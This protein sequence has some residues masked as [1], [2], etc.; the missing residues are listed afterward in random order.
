MAV[1][2]N[3]KIGDKEF[4]R[5]YG[6][7]TT[8]SYGCPS[9]E[10]DIYVYRMTMTNEDGDVVEYPWDLVKL[11]CEQM[12]AK[13]VPEFERFEFT[14]DV[15]LMARV[16]A[17]VGGSDPIGLKHVREGVVVR[18]ENKEHFSAYKHKN[19]EFKVLEG[20]IKET[21]VEPDM[22]ES[23]NYNEQGGGK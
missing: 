21:A 18:I 1:C 15:D 4:V 2:D 5:Q 17:V 12:G 7:T 20:S 9:G 6:A 8:F 19:F 14:D 16:N 11:R 23:E 22:E 10:N 3:R 13:I